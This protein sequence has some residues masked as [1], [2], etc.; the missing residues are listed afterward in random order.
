MV[1]EA[2]GAATHYGILYQ[3][4]SELAHTFTVDTV[5]P[6]KTP[7]GVT[8][9]IEPAGGGGDLVDR[10]ASLRR[11]YQ[12]KARADHSTWSMKQLVDSVFPDLLRAIDDVATASEY[13]FVTEG[14]EG[15]LAELWKLRSE[16][17]G[18]AVPDS[19]LDV[20][21]DTPRPFFPQ[22]LVS[23]KEFFR[24]IVRRA[25]K[26][27]ALTPDEEGQRYQKVWSLLA[28]FA[29]RTELRS[30]K[31]EQVFRLLLDVAHAR[32]DV[33]DLADQLYGY[34]LRLGG[35]GN[36]QL[37][38]E[39]LLRSVGVFFVPLSMFPRH[40]ELRKR[41][42]AVFR[43]VSYDPR[44]VIPRP[45]KWPTGKR[46]LAAAGKSGRG[47]TTLLA[48]LADEL[49]T[50]CP[51]V[52]ITRGKTIQ[53]ALKIAA[54][55]VWQGILRHDR[56]I[57]LEALARRA[58]DVGLSD[59]GDPWLTIV[60]DLTAARDDIREL[61]SLP[62]AEWNVRVAFS[63]TTD[64]DDFEDEIAVL[65]VNDFTRREVRQFL[66]LR[67]KE[68]H[69]APDAIVDTLLRPFDANTYAELTGTEGWRP[70]NR[71]A[72]NDRFW[73][74]I[75]NAP[76]KSGRRD[77]ARLLRLTDTL[78]DEVKYPWSAVEVISWADDQTLARLER[79]GWIIRTA[80]G[81]VRFRHERLLNWAVAHAMVERYRRDKWT[82][83]EFAD[84]LA[85]SHTRQ[86][87][88]EQPYLG[89]VA[90][91]VLWLGAT[92]RLLKD[93]ELALLLE[94]LEDADHHVHS[95][96]ATLGTAAV[97][98][99]IA[100]LA[101][102]E[103]RHAWVGHRASE[104][105]RELDRHSPLDA[106]VLKDMLVSS[107]LWLQD[108]ALTLLAQ[109]P[110]DSLLDRIWS[111]RNARNYSEGEFAYKVDYDG[112]VSDA[113]TAAARLRPAWLSAKILGTEDSDAMAALLVAVGANGA[114]PGR[115]L[116]FDVK[117]HVFSIKGAAHFVAAMHCIERYG[118]QGE[119]ERLKVWCHTGANFVP[120]A[121]L[122]ALAYLEPLEAIT[123]LATSA[124]ESVQW[125]LQAVLRPLVLRFPEETLEAVRAA[126]AA[127]RLQKR[128]IASSFGTSRQ[129]DANTIDLLI[130]R[131][132]KI[133]QSDPEGELPYSEATSRAAEHV[134]DALDSV[135]S[136]E[137]ITRLRAVAATEDG[138]SIGRYV[139][140]RLKSSRIRPDLFIRSAHSLLLKMGG[141]PLER[142]LEAQ[143]THLSAWPR[144][145]IRSIIASPTASSLARTHE[146]L[147]GAVRN[148]GTDKDPNYGLRQAC[149]ETI[150][151][152]EGRVATIRAIEASRGVVTEVIV[153]LLKGWPP[154]PNEITAELLD[155]FRNEQSA[156]RL[157]LLTLTGRGDVLPQIIGIMKDVPER[158]A[159]G[160][161]AGDTLA[162]LVTRE[163]PIEH[164]LA[165]GFDSFE[166]VT[167]RLLDEIR[168][169]EA[170]DVIERHLQGRELSD[171]RSY[172]ARLAADLISRDGRT[173]LAPAVW[174][175]FEAP[176]WILW[177]DDDLYVAIA[178]V[179]EDDVEDLLLRRAFGSDGRS[180]TAAAIRGLAVQNPALAFK[181]AMQVLRETGKQRSSVVDLLFKI[182]P[183]QALDHVI[184][185][186]P[187]ER[188]VLVRRRIGKALRTV[189]LKD[190]RGRIAGLMISMDAAQRAAGCELA[191]W[192]DDFETGRLRDLA[193]NDLD[194]MVRFFAL[195]ALE[196]QGDR[197][198][199]Q[200]LLTDLETAT[201]SRAWALMQILI[202]TGDPFLVIEYGDALSIGPRLAGQ[203]A[204]LVEYAEERSSERWKEHIDRSDRDMRDDFYR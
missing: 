33:P 175:A 51:V 57:S 152:V 95:D 4:L 72:L 80:D 164:V 56:E 197:R 38:T 109:R 68:G 186:M 185:H 153:K 120:A 98:L 19:P 116:W 132:V 179:R 74:S 159:L 35:K 142:F 136:V 40:P 93:S 131:L 168:T 75:D 6:V 87:T 48:Q 158:S 7:T 13:Y 64:A 32:E 47:K 187:Q 97:P 9:T 60:L 24:R 172:P 83:N 43:E 102:L 177:E 94:R 66:T 160:S 127:G 114:S 101:N 165:L 195:S 151:A 16:L 143:V 54:G 134:L 52:F 144:K 78:L 137:G 147:I 190:A 2:G 76:G 148:P 155:A 23:P 180:P 156:Y 65:K 130:S 200:D 178:Q 140:G 163:T 123:F 50:S 5:G 70:E 162:A 202:D 204:A 121:A 21:D 117:P 103:E 20:L 150:A 173:S 199:V 105:L 191:G 34:V 167:L 84:A 89:D 30:E 128:E 133:I 193:F 31:E 63:A 67:G 145:A 192:L 42:E 92:A 183:D 161:G 176:S 149:I 126:L 119:V 171:Q 104:V 88:T 170:I 22:E 122:R 69:A 86:R 55:A 196:A 154:A 29:I 8:I 189:A 39:R 77:T 182:D 91:D 15:E 113:L 90:M 71:Y 108:V 194:P 41:L 18:V 79:V 110:D 96:V 188:N 115:E 27:Q 14:T 181:A 53:E 107:S 146:L 174:K 62:L 37:T 166:Y 135:G 3:I 36:Q 157:A 73:W 203:S 46:L 139:V 112:R 198:R 184:E 138:A 28:N 26:K 201:G 11:V 17:A 125:L 45:T 141:E 118:D 12:Y 1:T 58:A 81:E 129:L 82:I 124:L 59:T 106:V 169:D 111:L 99:L 61:L 44:T 10:T 100:R 25:Y 85:E 49:S